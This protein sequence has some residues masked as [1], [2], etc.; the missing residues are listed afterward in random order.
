M[1]ENLFVPGLGAASASLAGMYIREGCW[2]ALP[3]VILGSLGLK[4][5]R[6]IY[7]VLGG[8]Q[9]WILKIGKP[10]CMS[11]AS[12]VMMGAWS[13]SNWSEMMAVKFEVA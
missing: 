8:A 11:R 9:Y 5:Q 4:Q 6:K 13:A 1:N 7:S 12:S 3:T 2:T 10:E